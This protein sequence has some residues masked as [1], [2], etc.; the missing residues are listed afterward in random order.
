MTSPNNDPNYD[1][2]AEIEKTP[3]VSFDPSK[4]GG[5]P[6]NT[7]AKLQVTDFIK[8]VQDKDDNGRPKVFEDSGKPVMKAVFAVTQDGEK[9]SLWAKKNWVQGGLFRSL[10]E[11]QTALAREEGEGTRI[12]PGTEL[13]IRWHWDTSKPKKL[14]NHPKA[15]EVVAK[16]A[17]RGQ[18]SDPLA[19]APVGAPASSDP[20]STPSTPVSDEP[21]F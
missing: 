20:W 10:A 1:P 15:Y 7:W 16:G 8:L 19:S 2:L 6:E 4:E 3:A 18:A 5:I 13:A 17:G 11:A 21:P 14:G 9:K 12:G